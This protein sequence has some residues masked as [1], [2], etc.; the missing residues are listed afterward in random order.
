MPTTVE[1]APA[2]EAIDYQQLYQAAYEQAYTMATEA[3]AAQ[4]RQE[5]EAA[6]AAKLRRLA[7]KQS[8]LSV[9]SEVIEV[10]GERQRYV[11]PPPEAPKLYEFKNVRDVSSTEQRKHQ[12]TYMAHFAKAKEA[13]INERLSRGQKSRRETASKYG[14]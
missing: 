1:V 11:L 14:F 8:D 7:G 10:K 12:I 6:E 3:A 5:A 2:A 4:A 13:E 9:T